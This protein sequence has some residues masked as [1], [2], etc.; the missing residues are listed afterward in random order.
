LVEERREIKLAV[1]S[2]P[3][4]SI[5]QITPCS[6]LIVASY[7]SQCQPIEI[8]LKPFTGTRACSVERRY[9]TLT[10][11]PLFGSYS[12]QTNVCT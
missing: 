2:A 4:V 8:R 9:A 5:Y 3:W 11:D 10:V 12:A 6:S 1:A 7:C